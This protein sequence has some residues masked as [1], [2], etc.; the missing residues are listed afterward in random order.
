MTNFRA[1]KLRGEQLAKDFDAN[2]S[3]QYTKE[4]RSKRQPRKR[5]FPRDGTIIKKFAKTFLILIVIG[6][7]VGGLFIFIK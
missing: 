3:H 7:I 2:C 1:F 4:I 6:I 5:I